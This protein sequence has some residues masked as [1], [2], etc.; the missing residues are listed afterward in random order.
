MRARLSALALALAASIPAQA[1]HFG[2]GLK[3]GE[4][5]A[6]SA[7][8]WTRLTAQPEA[9][10]AGT[11]FPQRKPKQPQ[12]PEGTP[13]AK[14]RGVLP[15][16]DGEIRIRYRPSGGAWQASA[17]Q[18]VTEASDHCHS[19]ALRELK[20]GTKYELIA[21]GRSGAEGPVAR[22]PGKLRT[23]P[24]A[25][26]TAALSFCVVACQEY[27]RRDDETKGH[28]IYAQMLRL[29]PAFLVHTGDTIYL[30]KAR[31][32]AVN[33]TLAR[34]KWNRFYALPL[35]RAF[36]N[37][38]S[39]YFMKDD[40][41]VLKN[42]CWP[43]QRYQDLSF[44]R[45][46]AIYQEQLPV[47][48]PPYRS[49]RWGRHLEVWFVEGREARSPNRDPDG[50]KKTIL[51]ATQKRWLKQS[52]TASNATFKVLI[53]PTPWIGPDR[54]GKRDNYANQNFQYE[55]KE[56]RAFLAGLD[57]SLV[58]CGDRHWQYVSKD[59]VT[60]LREFCSGSASDRHA[61]GFNMRMRSPM[62]EYLA[63]I[64]GF[65]HVSLELDEGKPSLVLTHRDVEGKPRNTVRMQARR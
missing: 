64:G 31:P 40:H 43:G 9:H 39:C 50:P 38:V 29:Q 36:H 24:D 62:H 56:M 61:G 13:L 18:A 32:F 4:V 41:D 46:N 59:P 16:A 53:S 54:G 23:A 11:P 35:Q 25:D 5:Q 10:W 19:F 27:H 45:G 33:E 30:D 12:L 58:I 57:N 2:N 7:L 28:K 47:G 17:W 8:V 63:I 37:Q 60:G 21:E 15:G 26:T 42:D 44:E 65:L 52:M 6:T 3:S 48:R 1:V 20:P 51:G 55:G 22:L 14:M 49:V 34:F